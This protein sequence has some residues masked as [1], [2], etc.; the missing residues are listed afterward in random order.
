MSFQIGTRL[1]VPVFTNGGTL[2]NEGPGILYYRDEPPVSSALYDGLLSPASSAALEGTQWLISNI[3]TTVSFRP[4]PT[5]AGP[6]GAQGPTGPQGPIGPAGADGTGFVWR[7]AWSTL[8]SYAV[9]DVVAYTADGFTSFYAVLDNSAVVPADSKPEW[10]GILIAGPAGPQGAQGI[11]GVPGP[12][13]A[14]GATGAQGANGTGFNWRGPW[15]AGIAYAVGDVV[16]YTADGFT[17]FIAI[18]TST[19]VTPANAAAQWDGIVI[20]GPAGPQGPQGPEGTLGTAKLVVGSTLPAMNVG[21]EYLWF[22]TDGAGV[23]LDI[24]GGIA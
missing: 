1:A 9:G 6:S 4:L 20:A 24:L 19:G 10:D 13:G 21:T 23:L 14:T 12:T 3:G 22:Q 8:T 2:R 7:G 5:T 17:S 15:G 11:Q 18:T 16:S